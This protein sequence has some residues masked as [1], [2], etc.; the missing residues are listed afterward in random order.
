MVVIHFVDPVLW[1][2]IQMLGEL[3]PQGDRYVRYRSERGLEL[4]V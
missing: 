2:G 3:T 1:V 4:R